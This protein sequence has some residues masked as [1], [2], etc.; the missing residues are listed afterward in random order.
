MERRT[1]QHPKNKH[2]Q[3]KPSNSSLTR[4]FSSQ[5]LKDKDKT[6]GGEDGGGGSGATSDPPE[7]ERAESVKERERSSSYWGHRSHKEDRHHSTHNSKGIPE[8]GLIG[9]E[10]YAR[11]DIEA[12]LMVV[13]G[14]QPDEGAYCRRWLVAIGVVV[15]S[16]MW[17]GAD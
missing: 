7:R 4:T 5:R 9:E 2:K 13:R 1:N 12:F 10:V 3:H 11:K 14:Y 6:A 16:L 15:G 8:F 17:V